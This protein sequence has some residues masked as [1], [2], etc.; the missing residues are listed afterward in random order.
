MTQP[1]SLTFPQ[2]LEHI[3]ERAG[4]VDTLSLWPADNIAD[5]AACSAMS[6]AIP[7]A[8]GGSQVD[9]VELHQRYEALCGA[10]LT[11]GLVF[12]QRDA[13]VGFLVG[14][15]RTPTV[16]RLLHEMARGQ[17]FCTIGISQLTTSRQHLPSAV[18][19]TPAP[20]GYLLRGAIPWVT[21]LHHNDRVIAGAVLP[22]AAQLLVALDTH[23]PGVELGP[24]LPLAALTGSDTGEVRLHDVLVP[25]ADILRGPCANALAGRALVREF[26]LTACVLP[27]G[28]AA[29][30]IEQ[31][32]SLALARSQ[33]CQDAIA[34]LAAQHHR[35]RTEIYAAAT[36]DQIDLSTQGPRLR[37]AANSLA[38][39]ATLAALE[40]A[41]GHGFLAG[42]PAQR[43][44]R[45]ALFFFVWS[46]PPAI[47]EQTL[48]ALTAPLGV[49]PHFSGPKGRN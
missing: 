25:H 18:T 38:A 45:E 36:S 28:V 29:A 32:A 20:G 21:S 41:K 17:T 10:C 2:A 4:T 3:A 33:A 19:A 22:D 7:H 6:W 49:P 40:L 48:A 11:T 34:E 35:L 1:A 9:P 42:E 14:S 26:K 27:L 43:R 13:A 30:A 47:I 8:D 39:R 31:A 5:L 44:A 24:P 23:A 46:S 16:Q 12:T 37:A 15:E